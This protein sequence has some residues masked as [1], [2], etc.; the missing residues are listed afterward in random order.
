[1]IFKNKE[2][3]E[4]IEIL[5]ASSGLAHRVTPYDFKKDEDIIEATTMATAEYVDY[6]YYWSQ[7]NDVLENFDESLEYFDT[8]SWINIALNGAAYDKLSDLAYKSLHKTEDYF[9][10]LLDQAEE[11]CINMWR[12]VFFNSN[13]KVIKHFFGKSI[14]FD[15]EVIES[16]FEDFYEVVSETRYAYSIEANVKNF[17]K[18]FL[19]KLNSKTTLPEV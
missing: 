9:S 18:T 16:I 8:A 15:A 10:K 5:N 2:D 17:C 11:K 13:A 7:I 12:I 14:K 4:K 3:R 19:A 6:A 1:M